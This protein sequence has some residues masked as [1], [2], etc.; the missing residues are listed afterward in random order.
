VT[1]L[2]VPHALAVAECHVWLARS[3]DAGNGLAGTLFSHDERARLGVLRRQSDR[4]RVTVGYALTRLAL[5]AYLGRPPGAVPISR[6][7]A[8][9]RSP[10]GKPRLAP[11]SPD[12][13]EFSVAHSG[14]RV[15]V[16]VTRAGP[17]GVDVELRS[18]RVSAADRD[19]VLGAGEAATLDRF[20][21]DERDRAFLVYWT[22]KEAILK[23]AGIGLA[24]SPADVVVTAPDDPP[25]L[26]S[27]PRAGFPAGS[28]SLHDLAVGAGYV[29]S[30]AV[31]GDCRRVIL[32]D[33]SALVAHWRR[34]P[35]QP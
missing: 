15:A 18:P 28:L 7:C 31:I 29:A 9:C 21:G 2:R 27:W 19:L 12:G 22:R 17:V 24:V 30:L 35:I 1:N 34:V 13:I 23:A 14:D 11:A 16:A 32:L 5:A 8:T 33:G 10:H 3:S 26:V 4:A 20:A 25:R 6:A